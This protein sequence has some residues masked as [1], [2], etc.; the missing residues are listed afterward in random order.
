MPSGRFA[1][2]RVYVGHTRPL[3]S[4]A[5]RIVK[6]RPIYV[7]LFTTVPYYDRVNIELSRSFDEHELHA[8]ERI[9]RVKP[10]FVFS[11]LK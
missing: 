2:W 3:C 7:T 4:L 5:A 8:R 6:S 9:R 10:V 1:D 11:P